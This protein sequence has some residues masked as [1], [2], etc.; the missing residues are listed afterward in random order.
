MLVDSESVNKITSIGVGDWLVLGGSV[1]MSSWRDLLGV[2]GTFK[3][4]VTLSY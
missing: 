1:D 3:L 2:D 4:G